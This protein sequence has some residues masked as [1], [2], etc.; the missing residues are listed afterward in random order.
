MKL[1][2]HPI[3]NT[4][5]PIIMFAADSGIDLD[6][7]VVDLFK[8]EHM[9]PPYATL[10]PN[11]LV[12]MLE[13]GDFRMTEASA[14]LKYLA[15]K[16]NSPAYPKDLQKRARVNERMDWLNTQFYRD[17]GYGLIYP[18]L[19]PNLKRPNDEQQNGVVAWGK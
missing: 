18:Q 11:C 15:D 10:N 4:S 9:Q 19:F 2:Y 1:Y 13:D 3:S 5:R 12:P 16:T 17:W 14:I 8:G 6:M 7:Q